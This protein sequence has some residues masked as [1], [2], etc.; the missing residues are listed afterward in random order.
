MEAT[1]AYFKVEYQN[2]PGRT[3]KYH[4]KPQLELSVPGA[5][6]ETNTTRIQCYPFAANQTP[7]R[8]AS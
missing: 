2:L 4:V 3:K 5:R 1:E 7:L 6:F 8:D